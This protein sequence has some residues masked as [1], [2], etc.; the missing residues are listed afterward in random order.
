MLRVGTR[1]WT[2]CR[3]HVP[4]RPAIGRHQ[5]SAS[6]R[7]GFPLN[8]RE[9]NLMRKHHLCWL[10]LALFLGRHHPQLYAHF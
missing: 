1:H 7:V 10:K 5:A 4:T 8:E 9:P 6:L 2:C 3:N